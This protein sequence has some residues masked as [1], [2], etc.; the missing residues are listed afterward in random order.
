MEGRRPSHGV[1]E[2]G[3]SDRPRRSRPSRVPGTEKLSCA[4]REPAAAR[5]SRDGPGHRREAAPGRARSGPGLPRRL[6]FVSV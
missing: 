1:V 4:R 5:G 6:P 3:S 2:K